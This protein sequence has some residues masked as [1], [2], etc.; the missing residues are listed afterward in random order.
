MTALSVLERAGADSML[1]ARG[2]QVEEESLRIVERVEREVKRR[3]GV[4][5]LGRQAAI[6]P[7]IGSCPL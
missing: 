3:Q 4:S 1:L 5:V 6:L 7:E 2:R